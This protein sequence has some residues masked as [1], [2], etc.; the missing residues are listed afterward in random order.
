M[1]SGPSSAP[2]A[3]EHGEELLAHY[4]AE[5][6]ETNLERFETM[7]TDTGFVCPG[8]D[9]ASVAP[10]AF[11]YHLRHIPENDPLDLGATEGVEVVSV[12]EHPEGVRAL[13][14]Q[15]GAVDLQF[16]SAVQEMLVN[17]ATDGRPSEDCPEYGDDGEVMLLDVPFE[18]TDEIRDSR[19]DAVTDSSVGAERHVNQSARPS[20]RACSPAHDRTSSASSTTPPCISTLPSTTTLSTTAATRAL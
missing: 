19:C 13:E 11:A 9:L 17:I 16:S 6:Y 3:L 2:A 12:F 7:W 4:P 1:G 5:E 8:L 14:V 15:L 18:L 10:T 20:R